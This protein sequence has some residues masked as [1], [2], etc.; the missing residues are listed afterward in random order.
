MEQNTK[1]KA[2][3]GCKCPQ[4]KIAAGTKAGQQLHNQNERKLRRMTKRELRKAVF[5][6][7]KELIEID[8]L[9][10]ISSPRIG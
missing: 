4:C 8:V 2:H 3:R 6:A 1:A 7:Q 9:G 5:E 10:S